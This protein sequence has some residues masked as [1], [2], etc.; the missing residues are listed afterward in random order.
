MAN[1]GDAAGTIQPGRWFDECGIMCRKLPKEC[2]DEICRSGDNGPAVSKWAEQLNFL[3]GLD[4][5][6]ARGHIMES[7][8]SSLLEVAK[9]EDADVAKWVLWDIAWRVFDEDQEDGVVGMCDSR[10]FSQF[11]KE[12]VCRDWGYDNQFY[13]MREN[14]PRRV[15]WAAARAVHKELRERDP[16][17]HSWVV[18][19]DTMRGDHC[20][21]CSCGFGYKWDSSD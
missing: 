2:V 14:D 1:D 18:A 3:D 16:G 19:T 10:R 8:S 12:R 21:R 11:L 9:M 6:L 5:D 15:Q 17:H 4:Q 7:G 20:R 13:F